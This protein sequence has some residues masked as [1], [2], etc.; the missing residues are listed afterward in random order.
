MFDGVVVVGGG[1]MVREV[2]V[3]EVGACV[4]RV[5]K[6]TEFWTAGKELHRRSHK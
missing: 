6:K 5:Q 1:Y 4:E 3:V 2:V